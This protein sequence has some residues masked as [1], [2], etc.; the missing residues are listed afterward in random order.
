MIWEAV[1][2]FDEDRLN[3]FVWEEVDDP[4]GKDEAAFFLVVKIENGITQWDDA[5]P[6]YVSDK[7]KQLWWLHV[8]RWRCCRLNGGG[9][10]DD[11]KTDSDDQSNTL[12]ARRRN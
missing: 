6:R 8:T 10:E 4:L 5:Q 1:P 9:D 2:V 3:A 12:A 11:G 7:L